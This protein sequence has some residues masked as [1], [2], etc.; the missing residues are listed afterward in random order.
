M[1]NS[2]HNNPPSRNV[3]S[4]DRQFTV[5]LIR[6]EI[7]KGLRIPFYEFVKKYREIQRYYCA[8]YFVTTTNKA[9]CEAVEVTPEN[10]TRY[11]RILESEGKLVSSIDDFHCPYT[12][13]ES[14]LLST[15]PQ[16]FDELRESN[17]NQLSLFDDEE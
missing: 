12:G 7:E 11:K 8:L 2:T 17:S 4:K 13:R 3:P 5:D 10:G 9:A 1:E 14:K 16:V 15:N 6:K